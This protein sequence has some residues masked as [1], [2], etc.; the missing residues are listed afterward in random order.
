M[1]RS[2]WTSSSGMQ[3]AQLAV[4]NTAHNVANVNTVGYR[5]SEVDFA[6]LLYQASAGGRLDT[7]SGVYPSVVTRD[8]TPG[9]LEAT[10]GE[11]DLAVAGGGFF[12]VRV[13]PTEL[14]YTRDGS[15]RRDAQGAIV[16]ANGFELDIIPPDGTTGPV[17]IPADA[18]G[19]TV[20]EDGAVTY[21]LPG[22][23]T[24][25]AAGRIPLWVLQPQVPG[26]S[27]EMLPRGENLFELGE[28]TA[29][30]AAVPG[31]DGSGVIKQGYLERSNV[32]LADEM[33][34]LIIAQRAYQLNA[35]AVQTADTMLALANNIRR[36]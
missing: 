24:P 18:T 2:L 35:R 28:G 26:R 3:A 9:A 4:D 25:V 19:I 22:T 1:I 33:V 5:R 14:L 23:E 17:R 15:F 32:S 16:N 10:G 8:L 6:D 34:T 11:F 36:G 30:V 27:A 21:L 12:A 7:G 13:N 20:G 29:V 31:Q